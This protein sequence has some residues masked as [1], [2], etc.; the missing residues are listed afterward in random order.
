MISAP[1]SEISTRLTSS[2][3]ILACSAGNSSDHRS[4][5]RRSSSRTCRSVRPLMACL[6]GSPSGDDDL[7]GLNH[8]LDLRDHDLFDLSRRHPPDR[9]S[10]RPIP[11]HIGRNVV[12]VSF[13]FFRVWAGVMAAPVGPKIRPFSIAGER[14]VGR[15]ARF[16]GLSEISAWTWSQRS[17]SM[18]ASCSPGCAMPLWTASPRYTRLFRTR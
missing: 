14:P 11:D 10:A 13:P 17:R 1:F 18:I 9:A 15:T 8:G 4:S 2:W 7:R 5:K 12:A 16:L 6:G 3:T